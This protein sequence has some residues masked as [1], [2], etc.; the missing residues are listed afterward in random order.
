VASKTLADL[1]LLD[2]GSWFSASFIGERVPTLE[3]M[4]TNTLPFAT[5]LIERKAGPAVLYVEEL[6]RLGVVSNVVVQAFDWNFLAA[7]HASNRVSALAPW[8]TGRSPPRRS[9]PSR[10]AAP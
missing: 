3:E 7:V 1:N 4:I 2:A 8:A 5:P 6:Q 10:T 9:P